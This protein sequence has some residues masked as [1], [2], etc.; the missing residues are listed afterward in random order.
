MGRVSVVRGSTTAALVVRVS[1]R[2]GEGVGVGGG[3]EGARA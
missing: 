3:V 2:G 1:E